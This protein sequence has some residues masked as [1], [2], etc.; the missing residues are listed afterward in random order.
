MALV[1]FGELDAFPVNFSQKFY[2]RVD[3]VMRLTASAGSNS[4]GKL[5]GQFQTA[6]SR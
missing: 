5:S 4:S 6:P 1:F 3:F 2:L